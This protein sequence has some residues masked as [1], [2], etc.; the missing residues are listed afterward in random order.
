MLGPKP[1][2]RCAG[3]L[4]ALAVLISSA[5]GA[6]RLDPA[7]TIK[8]AD[9][10]EVPLGQVYYTVGVDYDT[11]GAGT[12]L[13][14]HAEVLSEIYQYT[15]EAKV[16]VA[17]KGTAAVLILLDGKQK[18]GEVL[19]VRAYFNAKGQTFNELID[20]PGVIQETTKVTAILPKIV[21]PVAK[22][23][24]LPD[25]KP[26]K[27]QV[28]EPTIEYDMLNFEVDIHLTCFKNQYGN[29]YEIFPGIKG[30]GEMQLKLNF[31]ALK[32]GTEAIIEMFLTPRGK[33][34]QAAYLP[35]GWMQIFQHYGGEAA[36]AKAA[37]TEI[38]EFLTNP[39]ELMV[40][41]ENG[42]VMEPV[43]E[44]T[45]L[46]LPE[47]ALQLRFVPD[48]TGKTNRVITVHKNGLVWL[49]DSPER[50][51]QATG[52][53]I[54]DLR[55][56]APSVA[57]TYEARDNGLSS[58]NFD[59]HWPEQPY[60]Y[61]AYTA[62][63][64]K[65]PK[66][67]GPGGP[68][69]W[70]N[71]D[72]KMYAS[73]PE[74]W[75]DEC[76][77][78]GSNLGGLHCEAFTHIE[79]FKYAIEPN[80]EMVERQL[81]IRDFCGDSGGHGLTSLEWIIPAAGG[82]P[83][84]T[85]GFGDRQASARTR[86]KF[87]AVMG[88]P[89]PDVGTGDPAES[90]YRYDSMCYD[91]TLGE[92]QGQFR[93]QREEFMHGKM[94]AV[95]P[96]AYRKNERIFKGDGFFYVAQ[97]FR[98]PMRS[99]PG[100]DGTIIIANVGDGES[101]VSE[102]LHQFK[103]D[104]TRVVEANFCWPCVEGSQLDSNNEITRAAAVVQKGW[105]LC[106]GCF[107]SRKQP[108]PAGEKVFLW[109]KYEYRNGGV[110]YR[111]GS[112]A[113]KCFTLT[114]ALTAVLY[115]NGDKLP[116]PYQNTIFFSDFMK[117]CLFYF[118]KDPDGTINFNKP[119]VLSAYSGFVDLTQGPD[120]HIYGTDYDFA[121]I[122]RL[123]FEPDLRAQPVAITG[124]NRPRPL[125]CDNRGWMLHALVVRDLAARNILPKTEDLPQLGIG[126][127]QTDICRA[128]TGIPLLQWHDCPAGMRGADWQCADLDFGVIEYTTKYG[129][130]RY[131]YEIPCDHGGGLHFYHAH[132]HGSAA[133]QAGG[134][135]LGL[136]VI[137]ENPAFEGVMPVGLAG[138]PEQLLLVQ[139][140]APAAVT[141]AAAAMLDT[142][143]RTNAVGDHYLV[144]G[145]DNDRF[146]MKAS[147]ATCAREP[148]A[149][150]LRV[151]LW[152]QAAAAG[153]PAGRWTRVRLLH[154]GADG[155]VLIRFGACQVG[156]LAKDG[157]YLA[158]V[159]RA[160]PDATIFASISSR[161]DF[162][163]RC[164]DI[165]VQL[166]QLQQ[167]KL[168]KGTWD[169]LGTIV[170]EAPPPLA[171]KLSTVMEVDAQGVPRAR[172]SM[173]GLA[174]AA[175]AP[176]FTK[177]LPMW[178]PCR[179]AY[180]RDLRAD[181]VA[182]DHTF[183][184]TLEGSINRTPYAQGAV[185]TTAMLGATYEW[186]AEMTNQH[187]LHMHVNHVQLLAPPNFKEARDWHRDGD[188]VDTITGSDMVKFRFRPERH[189]FGHS[190][191]GMMAVVQIQGGNTAPLGNQEADAKTA[192]C[193]AQP[194]NSRWYRENG[195]APVG[196]P[197]RPAAPK[198]GDPTKSQSESAN[199]VVD[200]GGAA[201]NVKAQAAVGSAVALVA[202]VAIAV[203]A[204]FAYKRW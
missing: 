177:T 14:M 115:Y 141:S 122:T 144:N 104:F 36:A 94:V 64:F 33:D 29:G 171:A 37:V 103:P 195:M 101:T 116:A 25:L 56:D 167:L 107:A 17:G 159:P 28:W 48:A 194:D 16:T 69:N 72:A 174:A 79:R 109:P 133:V 140:M 100:P 24:V 129:T 169:D 123:R 172:A 143:W 82:E 201:L 20:P 118:E 187:P 197:E 113:S 10:P 189:V 193:P 151:S 170:V 41:V 75:A 145:C 1:S 112:S 31:P 146:K 67:P 191:L 121:R 99:R 85:F 15:G 203:G 148:C 11:G 150:S 181:A 62:D 139:A 42:L 126:Y 43:F 63:D 5:T 35:P 54:L 7:P 161:V 77:D 57:Q 149:C 93:A 80:W 86:L 196:Q 60:L 65:D 90:G 45:G 204:L 30:K 38:G 32:A 44:W 73:R 71:T 114:G 200:T 26:D 27:A 19:T 111:G 168:G 23:T 180:L 105:K 157:A 163:L 202:A 184:I 6:I 199:A 12:Q 198:P 88:K 68:G 83:Y 176:F 51:S 120:G 87:K 58:C 132:H 81:L 137:E 185:M 3:V 96:E 61:C 8:L 156:V 183:M 131:T 106:D 136:V 135:A 173:R 178:R 160:A 4:A 49:F 21:W 97:G 124:R 59:P 108:E 175:P 166:M 52:R 55:F 34:Y 18:Q 186:T 70:P 192:A 50:K 76:Y 179:P 138:M 40:D 119:R 13:D 84:L 78:V 153:V 53:I 46:K 162:A 165:G 91:P 190:D 182:K 98:N 47:K 155:N 127:Q 130:T 22:F 134:G 152:P 102:L 117:Q 66:F 110:D 128:D 142:V 89:N 2:L 92:P 74:H 188:W 147:A 154:G 158:E 95:P 125:A 39:P 164:P 9:V